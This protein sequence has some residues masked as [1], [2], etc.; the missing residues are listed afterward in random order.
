MHLGDIE[1]DPGYFR[2]FSPDLLPRGVPLPDLSTLEGQ[3]AVDEAIGAAEV[4]VLDNLSCWCRSGVENDGESWVS[5]QEWLS[6]L[7]RRGIST[8]LVHHAGKNGQQRGTSRREDMLDTVLELRRPADFDPRQGCK[9][10]ISF[11]K[12]RHLSGEEAQSLSMQMITSPDSRATWTWS[13][14][15]SSTFEKVADLS[16]EGLSPG[17]I[18]S[19]LGVHK[20]SVSRHLRAAR[21]A[22]VLEGRS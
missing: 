8:I 15:E 9:F 21:E 10:E 16:R 17:E 7:R 4:V 6:T 19:E 11:S 3:G 13:T 1:P 12:A 22:G 5:V 18:A 14:L 2:I 20:S